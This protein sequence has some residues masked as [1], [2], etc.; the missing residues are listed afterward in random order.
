MMYGIED[1]VWVALGSP[2][3]SIP[4]AVTPGELLTAA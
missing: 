3:A 1:G 4:T 2:R